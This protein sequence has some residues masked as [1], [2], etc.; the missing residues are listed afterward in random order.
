MDIRK[1][2]DGPYVYAEEEDLGVETIP[3]MGA[4]DMDVGNL[5]GGREGVEGT[6]GFRMMVSASNQLFNSASAF[7]QSL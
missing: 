1:H 2:L 4:E 5:V 7:G 3:V 6:S